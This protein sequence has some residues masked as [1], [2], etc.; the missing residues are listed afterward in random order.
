MHS[1]AGGTGSGL[2]AWVTEQIRRDYPHALMMNVVVWPYSKGE[3]S[4]QHFNSLLTLSH[5]YPVRPLNAYSL[6]FRLSIIW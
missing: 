2:G 5:V 4:V 6:P 1:L 3:V